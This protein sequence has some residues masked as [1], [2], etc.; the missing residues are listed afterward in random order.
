MEKILIYEIKVDVDVD[1]DAELDVG[2][3]NSL[4]PFSPG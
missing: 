3:Y 2:K 1:Y 4:R